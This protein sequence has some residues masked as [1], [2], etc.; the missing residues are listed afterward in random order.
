MRFAGSFFVDFVFYDFFRGQLKPRVKDRRKIFLILLLGAAG[1]WVVNS[2]GSRLASLVIILL[3]LAGQQQLLFRDDGKRELFLLL[4]WE[5]LA[6]FMELM[7]GLFLVKFPLWEVLR[8]TLGYDRSIEKSLMGILIYLLCWMVLRGLKAY[9]L[10][11]KC[12]MGERIPLSFFLLLLST[13]LIYFGA[14]FGDEGGI[15]A[16]FCLDMG[17]ILLPAANISMFYTFMKLFYISEKNREQQLAEQQASLQQ[18]YYRHLEEIDLGH[19]RYAHDLKNCMVSIGTLAASGGNEEILVLLGDMEVELDALTCRQY[20]ANSI[21]NA[22]LWEKTSLAKRHGVRMEVE[23]G[24]ETEWSR[25]PGR[26]LIVMVGNLLDN[27]I[28]A[29]EQ[30]AEGSVHVALH[31]NG[32]FLVAQVENTCSEMLCMDGEVIRSTKKFAENHGFGISNARDAAEKYGG[33]LHIEQKG[34]SFIA[35]LTIAKVCLPA[36]ADTGA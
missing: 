22:L 29:A 16:Q 11:T 17:H 8:E 1:I 6:V 20:T 4:I 18:R 2:F 24:P 12:A 32:H 9:F 33:L 31:A 7:T 19:R 10:S 27:A 13:F 21:L 28:E 30:C 15:W 14:F 25:V 34:D 36:P 35:I 3:M 26:D 5:A 23:A